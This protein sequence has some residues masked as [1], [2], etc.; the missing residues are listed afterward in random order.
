M[1]YPCNDPEDQ[2]PVYAAR[3]LGDKPDK[4]CETDIQ[5]ALHKEDLTISLSAEGR[6]ETVAVLT[7]CM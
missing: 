6:S 1:E 7:R 3:I 2:L 5:L 4:I